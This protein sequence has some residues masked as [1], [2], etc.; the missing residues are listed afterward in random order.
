MCFMCEFADQVNAPL[1]KVLDQ[2][3]DDFGHEFERLAKEE[4]PEGGEP[5]AADKIRIQARATVLFHAGFKELM[6][7]TQNMEGCM[8]IAE[9]AAYKVGFRARK[10]ILEALLDAL[11]ESQPQHPVVEADKDRR[12]N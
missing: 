10:N 12:G 11:E 8:A 3:Q 5:D 9:Q 1:T 6:G 4:F 2:H 7:I